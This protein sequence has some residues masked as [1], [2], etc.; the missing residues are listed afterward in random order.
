MLFSANFKYYKA[1]D[2]RENGCFGKGEGP[3]VKNN[4]PIMNFWIIA[5][6]SIAYLVVGEISNVVT[7]SN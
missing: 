2:P 6:I 4:S 7:Q 3:F 5:I 1:R